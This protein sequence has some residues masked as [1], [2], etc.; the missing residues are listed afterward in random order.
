MQRIS[1]W[2]SVK[3]LENSEN[4]K[5]KKG[6][7]PGFQYLPPKMFKEPSI[8]KENLTI[9]KGNSSYPICNTY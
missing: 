4:A 6:S 7:R 5:I 2:E 8:F 9:Y 1:L 3:K